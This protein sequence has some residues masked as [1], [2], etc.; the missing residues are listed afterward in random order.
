MTDPAVLEQITLMAKALVSVHCALDRLGNNDA[1]TQMG[2]IENHAKE[3]RE[4][5]E[6]IASAIDNLADAIRENK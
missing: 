1:A 4:G 5:S 6:R 2:A 3:I